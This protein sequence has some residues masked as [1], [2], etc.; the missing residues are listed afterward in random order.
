VISPYVVDPAVA[1]SLG[2]LVAGGPRTQGARDTYARVIE[3]VREGYLLHYATPRVIATDDRDLAL[4]AGDYLY[5]S[6]LSLLAGM[7]DAGAVSELADLIS[8][9][10]QAHSDGAAD[11]PGLWLAA[12]VAI[13]V[14]SGEPHVAAKSAARRGLPVAAE[15][16]EWSSSVAAQAGLDEE[17]GAAAEAVGFAR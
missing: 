16:W 5:A 9:C 11:V 13:A 17:L 10:A 2:E 4:L 3:S 14:G 1:P 15:L 6:G 12:A 8:L 7:G